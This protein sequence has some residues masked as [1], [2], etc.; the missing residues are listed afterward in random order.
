MSFFLTEFCAMIY[1][2]GNPLDKLAKDTSLK[3][4]RLREA[5]LSL[6]PSSETRKKL[7]RKMAT[8]D[9]GARSTRFSR[10]FLSHFA[11]RTKRKDYS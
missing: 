9:P 4:T 8:R 10:R 3:H 2:S 5:P 1:I 11:R 7:A 6:S